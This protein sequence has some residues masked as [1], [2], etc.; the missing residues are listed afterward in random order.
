[1]RLKD[2]KDIYAGLECLL[3]KGQSCQ[4]NPK[5]SYSERKAKHEPLGHSLSLISSISSFNSKENKHSVYT[6]KLHIT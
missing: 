5:E 2:M 1:M 4:N 6:K 3:I